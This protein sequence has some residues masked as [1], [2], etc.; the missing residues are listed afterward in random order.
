MYFTPREGGAAAQE[1]F[2]CP[3]R[4]A[5][6]ASLAT[7]VLPVCHGNLGIQTE[8]GFFQITRLFLHPLLGGHRKKKEKRTGTSRFPLLLSP[9]LGLNWIGKAERK[10]TSLYFMEFGGVL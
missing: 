8:A 7:T 5:A 1:P 9:Q 4:D 2:V 6:A 10:C 3:R